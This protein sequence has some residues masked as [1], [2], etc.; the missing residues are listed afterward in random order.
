MP[1]LFTRSKASVRSVKDMYSG[2]LCSLHFSCSCLMERIMSMV[3]FGE[4]L[5]GQ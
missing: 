5:Q 2:S 3:T 4:D 1:S